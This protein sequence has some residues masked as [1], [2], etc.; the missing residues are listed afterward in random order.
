MR[1][2]VPT[3]DSRMRTGCGDMWG[4][5]LWS[6]FLCGSVLS[7]KLENQQSRVEILGINFSEAVS[8]LASTTSGV[9][10]LVLSTSGL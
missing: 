10:V 2:S 4:S 7:L 1:S 6:H 9:W 3:V 8:F 5:M